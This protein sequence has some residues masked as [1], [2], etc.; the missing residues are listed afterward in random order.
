LLATQKDAVLGSTHIS[1]MGGEDAHKDIDLAEAQ[2]M[3]VV[4]GQRREMRN[5]LSPTTGT[6]AYQFSQQTI[7]ALPE[8]EDTSLTKILQQAPGVAE[9]SAASGGL[10]IRGE[11]ADLQ[12]RLN[13]ILLP[14]GISGFGDTIDAHVIENATL[15]DGTLPAQY[16]FRTAGVVDIDTRTASPMAARR[17]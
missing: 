9:D 8:G 16:G 14:E 5:S 2:T 13:G 6:S 3:N 11:H 4:V 17:N 10:H 15:L 1:V 7:A 12:Y